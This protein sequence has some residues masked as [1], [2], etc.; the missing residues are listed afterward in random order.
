MH[1]PDVVGTSRMDRRRIGFL[2]KHRWFLMEKEQRISVEQ[3]RSERSLLSNFTYKWQKCCSL[4]ARS[5]AGVEAKLESD[6]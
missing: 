5:A 3:S 6:A 2:L 1:D 4:L